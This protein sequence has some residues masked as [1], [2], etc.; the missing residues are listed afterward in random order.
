MNNHPDL[1]FE[2]HGDFEKLF[3]VSKE[4]AVAIP[5]GNSNPNPNRN[6]IN[7]YRTANSGCKYGLKL[8]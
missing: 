1:V 5:K 8:E 6:D 3:G 2:P 4:Q 7:V